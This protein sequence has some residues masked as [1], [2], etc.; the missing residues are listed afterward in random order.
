MNTP[1]LWQPS[2]ASDGGLLEWGLRVFRSTGGGEG[3]V[4]DTTPEQTALARHGVAAAVITYSDA[5]AALQ[6]MAAPQWRLA[7]RGAAHAWRG[8]SN[9][10]TAGWDAYVARAAA[11][12]LDALSFDSEV[13][14]GCCSGGGALT[15]VAAQVAAWWRTLDR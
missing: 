13:G 8:C 6:G 9:L 14:G 5:A 11:C 4:P 12:R 3:C 15:A 2:A 1:V 7:A 10:F